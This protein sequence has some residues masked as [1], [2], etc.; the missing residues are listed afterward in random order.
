[1]R[2][3]MINQGFAQGFLEY[4]NNVLAGGLLSSL[5]SREEQSEIIA[6]LVLCKKKH[7]IYNLHECL[8]AC[9]ETGTAKDATHSGQRH[10]HVSLFVL[11]NHKHH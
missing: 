5:F 7:L 8:G 10:D 11:T 9:H 3:N 1:M 6:E 4:I 2:S